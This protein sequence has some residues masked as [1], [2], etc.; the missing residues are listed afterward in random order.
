MSEKNKFLHCTVWGS[1][2]LS[3]SETV[4]DTRTWLWSPLMIL[5]FLWCYPPGVYCPDPSGI[6]LLK[7]NNRTSRTRC[8]ICFTPC[9]S[10]SFL[11]FEHVITG[12]GVTLAFWIRL[13]N[14]SW[15]KSQPLQL[16][17]QVFQKK[18]HIILNLYKLTLRHDI[19]KIFWRYKIP[20]LRNIFAKF[21][22]DITTLSFFIEIWIYQVK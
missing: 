16:I 4:H 10:V 12:W 13:C 8:E 15:M 21:P 19:W 5:N 14:V 9:S 18:L 17:Y 11:N 1:G 22:S 20:S 7:V 2:S 6:N 3:I